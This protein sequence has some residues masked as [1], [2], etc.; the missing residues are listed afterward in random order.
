[1]RLVVVG[2]GVAFEEGGMKRGDVQGRPWWRL[3]QG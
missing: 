1:M 3:A 2:V